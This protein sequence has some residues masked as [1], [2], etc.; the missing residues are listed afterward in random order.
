MT[1]CPNGWVCDDQSSTGSL[2]SGRIDFPTI[3]YPD[4]RDG[5][6]A[7]RLQLDPLWNE[8]TRHENGAFARRLIDRLSGERS[9]SEQASRDKTC[10]NDRNPKAH[11]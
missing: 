7:D 11:A 2:A 6:R 8:R 1:R 10:S 3:D 5:R 9:G 4:R